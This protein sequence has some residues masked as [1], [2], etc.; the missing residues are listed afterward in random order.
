MTTE[1]ALTLPQRAALALESSKTE[2]RLRELVA[3]TADM[4]EVL[5]KAARD[6]IHSA[7]MTYRDHRV[8]IEKTGKASRD[9]ATKF[10]K[11]VIAEES[12][13]I[14]I[15][16]PEEK[17]LLALRDAYD[18]KI[19]AEKQAKIAIERARVEAIQERIGKFAKLVLQAAG[20]G[21]EAIAG[22]QEQVEE[23]EITEVDF[24]EFQPQATT[25]K[26][27]AEEALMI[28]YKAAYDAEQA[29][30]AARIQ[31]EEEDRQRAAEAA[32][33]EAQRA[34]QA[35]I[36]EAQA[37]EAKRLHEES[38]AKIAEINRLQSEIQAKFKAERDAEEARQQA[39]KAAHD[40]EMKRQADELAVQRA[41]FEAQQ[42]EAERVKALEEQK[43]QDAAK[44]EADHVEA[45]EMNAAHDVAHEEWFAAQKVN[46]SAVADAMI[47]DLIGCGP[48]HDAVN[49]P[50]DEEIIDM[51]I[52]AFGGTPE[53][54]I[55]RLGRFELHTHA[56]PFVT[57]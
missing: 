42:Q 16:S 28:A 56:V 18:A 1:T 5:N 8:T 4:T 52:E 24:E 45:L 20:K 57:S 11:A 40:A 27:E 17:R 19:E 25:A 22:L 10:S 12:R 3:S 26:V 51:Y 2:V 6:Q 55:A 34:E 46:S 33:L 53:Q 9:D 21:S 15:I 44:L 43:R 31:R 23:I 13:L 50:T 35:K 7:A 36:S 30:E 54:A 37:A 39:A 32:T 47:A 48:L 14:E 38:L 29:I 49:E 41:A